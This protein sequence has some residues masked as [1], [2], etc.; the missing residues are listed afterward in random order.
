MRTIHQLVATL[1]PFDAVSNETR[2]MRDVLARRAATRRPSTP[3][4]STTR[5][6]AR[7]SR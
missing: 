1:A 4:T 5:C 3:R 7:P 6:A 2:A